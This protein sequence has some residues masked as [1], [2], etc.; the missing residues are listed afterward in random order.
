MQSLKTIQQTREEK[1]LQKHR[2]TSFQ[3]ER[4]LYNLLFIALDTG[5]RAVMAHEIALSIARRHSRRR[6]RRRLEQ[7]WVTSGVHID[8]DDTQLF[9]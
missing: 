7:P 3:F 1:N 8:I 4:S 5:S 2:Q 6:M 9:Q